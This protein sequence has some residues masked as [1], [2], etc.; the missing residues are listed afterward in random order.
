MP[1]VSVLDVTLMVKESWDT[2]LLSAV[3]PRTHPIPKE[4]SI[5]LS[6]FTLGFLGPEYAPPFP[7]VVT[8]SAS[9]W[10]PFPLPQPSRWTGRRDA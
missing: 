9:H 5:V 7:V 1:D 8:S 4:V 2:V 6:C 3:L 10:L